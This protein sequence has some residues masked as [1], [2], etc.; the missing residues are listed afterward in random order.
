MKRLLSLILVLSLALSVLSLA[1]AED[2]KS[3]NIG[4]TGTIST[5]NPLGM[6]ATEIVK[7]ATSLV[8]Q[9]LLEADSE[10]NFVPV[11]A[12]SIT[13]EDN[14]HFTIRLREDA[15]WS[16]GEPITAEDVEFT[17]VLAAD[18]QCANIS[19]AMY[20]IEGVSDEGI[21]EENAEHI[22]GI[23]VV[24]EHTLNVTAKWE[25]ALSTFENNFGRYALILPKH[26][27]K[28]VPRADLLTY[29]WFNHPDVISG[30]YFINDFDLQ[31]YVHYVAN[32]NYF[33]GAPKIKYLNINV[34][35]PSQLLAGL[36]S[37]EIDLIQQTMGAI[38]IEDY[39][40]VKALSNITAVPSTP[41]TNE[42]IFVNV[43]H[44]PDVRIRQALLY[45]MDRQTM[46]ENLLGDS[47]ALVDG[48]L[49][50]VS[51]Y[52]SDELGVTPY[53]PEKA[54]A[55]IAEAKA[56]GA[57]TSLTWYVS[58]E[59]SVFGNAVQYYAAMFEEIGLDISIRTV[60]LANLMTVVSDGDH[61]IL[62]VEYTLMP[63]DPYTDIAWLIGG[64][65]LWTGYTSDATDEAL[66]L[67]QSLTDPDQITEQ[68]LVINKAMQEDAPVISGW[69]IG[70]L[71]AVSNRLKNAS[72]DVFGTFIN[73]QDWDI[74]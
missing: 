21:I 2:A 58:S 13:T 3:A 65:S 28:D 32:E 66:A 56:D 6:D 38:P 54:A 27:L 15:K 11:I 18:P 64:Q 72:P 7:Y 29:D 16:D 62:S 4:V 43:S 53:D 60:D 9:S 73:V 47:G 34:V 37:G 19:L 61:D 59:E 24:D 57:E 30:P 49:A 44:V 67:S 25:T 63:A 41:V 39:D 20:S 33:L 70:K 55:L 8:F 69:I 17:L 42:L 10:L 14:L 35:A 1:S 46:I 45:G 71:G 68:Y 26:V 5:L 48:F 23:E 22:D 74:E 40:A 50:P 36:Q 52:F 51:P 31:H 12:E